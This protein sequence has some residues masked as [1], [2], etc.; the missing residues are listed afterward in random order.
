VR[1]QQQFSSKVAQKSHLSG[2][3]QMA[4]IEGLSYNLHFILST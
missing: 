1:A 3:R 4:M 2:I